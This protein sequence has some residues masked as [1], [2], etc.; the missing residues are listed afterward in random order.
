MGTLVSSGS[1]AHTGLYRLGVTGTGLDAASTADTRAQ[2]SVRERVADA[3]IEAM[4]EARTRGVMS[5]SASSGILSIPAGVTAAQM[6]ALLEEFLGAP[7]QT[8]D[9]LTAEGQSSLAQWSDTAIALRNSAASLAS[10]LSPGQGGGVHYADGRWYINGQPY[11]LAESFLALRVSTYSSLDQYLAEQ[12]NKAN[13]NAIVARRLLGLVSDL[14]ARYAARDGSA[15]S[16]DI[17][18]DVVDLLADNGLSLNELASWGTRV[19]GG[20]NFATVADAHLSGSSA[21]LSATTYAALITEA[22][23]L[24]DATN[25]ENQVGQVRMDG[26]VNA[27]QNV[28]DGMSSFMKGYDAQQSSLAR[29]LKG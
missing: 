3:I 13:S 2:V 4:R 25:A 29:M 19:S 17:Q 18:A 22:K 8:E 26:V 27:R 16:Y 24:F 20:G 11:T 15:G 1:T 14:N 23:A 5:F 21:A 28:V 12:M 10:R 7:S 6:D 9:G